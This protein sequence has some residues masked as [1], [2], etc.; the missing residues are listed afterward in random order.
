MFRQNASEPNCETAKIAFSFFSFFSN[1][2]PQADKRISQNVWPGGVRAARFSNEKSVV[3][4]INNSES[5]RK[6]SMSAMW[7]WPQNAIQSDPKNI[8]CSKT[9]FRDL[10]HV[11]MFLI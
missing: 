3:F 6:L 4:K 11:L 8:T 2:G 7:A 1:F 9:C 10:L 5:I